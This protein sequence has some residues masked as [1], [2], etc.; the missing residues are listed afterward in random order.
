[1][2]RREVP[3]PDA[4]VDRLR[5]AVAQDL[6]RTRRRD[7]S[8]PPRLACVDHDRG[9]EA[10]LEV[11]HLPASGR[12]REVEAV[13][14]EQEPDRGKADAAVR[15]VRR[16]HCVTPLAEEG[17]Q[18]VRQLAHRRKPPSGRNTLRMQFKG[19]KPPA[20]SYT[21]KEPSALNISRRTAS[22]RRAVRRP[23]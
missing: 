12:R 17:P 2:F 23:V 19:L 21:R 22:G 5:L 10:P 13:V 1:R 18:L 14:L 3:V 15:I 7:P 9:R 11:L 20:S 6:N 8:L 4:G 16:E